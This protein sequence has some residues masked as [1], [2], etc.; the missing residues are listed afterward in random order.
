[1]L[2]RS[3]A[4]IGSRQRELRRVATPTSPN[5][6]KKWGKRRNNEERDDYRGGVRSGVTPRYTVP[7]PRTRTQRAE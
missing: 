6:A 1:M 2:S 5:R 4:P 3:A 7:Q